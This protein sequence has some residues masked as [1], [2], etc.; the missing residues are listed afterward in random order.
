[1]G[2]K[3]KKQ[4]SNRGCRTLNLLSVQPTELQRL[5][6]DYRLETQGI[7]FGTNTY[8]AYTRIS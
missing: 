4:Q 7:S 2:S 6:T 8:G 3:F 5:T 1:M